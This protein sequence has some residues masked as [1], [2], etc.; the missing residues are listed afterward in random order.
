[1]EGGT[2]T[3]VRKLST[4]ERREEI[5]RMLSGASIT[6]EARAQA[7]RLLDAA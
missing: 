3:T 7:S 2:R 4:E 1:G 6:E 5:A